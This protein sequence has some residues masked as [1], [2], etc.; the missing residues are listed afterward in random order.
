M[1][2]TFIHAGHETSAHAL[3]FAV[4]FLALYPDVQQ[5]AYEE[6][7]EIWPDGCPTDASPSSY[8]EFMS[9]L[10]YTLAIFYEALRLFPTA[11]RICKIAR[12]DTTLTAHRFTSS[13]SGEIR[14]IT[15]FAVSVKEGSIL[16]IE[17]M[18]LQMS[19]LYWGPD[20][21]EF[22]PE[23]F[24]DTEEYRW[25]RDAFFAFASGPRSCIG[26]RFALVEGVC[27]LANLVRSF[28][29]LLPTPLLAKPFEEQKRLLLKWQPR[30]ITTPMNCAVRLRR[31]S[32]A[33]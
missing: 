2:F 8:K 4:A 1:F 31:R 14:D 16:V 3:S 30:V 29:V 15:P 27:L 33:A 25:P 21:N 20:T 17:V 11:S 5:K 28:E 13:P 7:L 19:P 23:R 12:T 32:A 6:T 18:A 22:K 26:Q 24:V 9:K 10:P